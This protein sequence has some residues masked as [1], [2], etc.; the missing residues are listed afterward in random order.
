MPIKNVKG[1]EQFITIVNVAQ[2]DTDSEGEG[3]QPKLQPLLMQYQALVKQPCA[4]N[5]P[6]SATRM[7][8][9][10]M[11]KKRDAA[12]TQVLIEWLQN[13]ITQIQQHCQTQ[14]QKPAFVWFDDMEIDS[15]ARV[16]SNAE[17]MA[18]PSKQEGFRA[19]VDGRPIHEQAVIDAQR[20]QEDQLAFAAEQERQRIQQETE[21]RQRQARIQ[22]ERDLHDRQQR[23]Q[24]AITRFQAL[25]STY[26]GSYFPMWSN[27]RGGGG[28]L[29]KIRDWPWAIGIKMGG[30]SDESHIRWFNQQADYASA[31]GREW[32]K[33]QE[34]Q[35]L[36]EIL[37]R[38][39]AF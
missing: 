34:M 9:E 30:N 29:W 33:G 26:M 23:L 8:P 38:A 1:K 39:N 19:Q 25:V 28:D 13:A 7:P 11:V 6:A 4:R 10:L 2:D 5:A 17:Q 21:A 35:V 22:R 12:H 3:D 36:D 18:Q 16:D 14:Q 32:I 27:I 15:Q 20:R 31:R 24:A 37:R